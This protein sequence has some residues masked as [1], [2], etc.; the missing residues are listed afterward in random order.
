MQGGEVGEDVLESPDAG[1]REFGGGGAPVLGPP[2]QR[3]DAGAY[4][5]GHGHHERGHRAEAQRFG[6]KVGN[7]AGYD[8]QEAVVEGGLAEGRRNPL[9]R[10]TVVLT[11]LVNIPEDD[12]T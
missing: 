11:V 10:E 1:E 3:P 5:E 6:S 4:Q 12:I 7:Y 8:G 9:D 2:Q